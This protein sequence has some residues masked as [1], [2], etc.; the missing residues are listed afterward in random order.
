VLDQHERH[1]GVGRQVREE[2]GEGF[3][4]AGRSPDADDGEVAFAR[5]ES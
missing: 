1:A 5:G 2:L 3:Q 4:A